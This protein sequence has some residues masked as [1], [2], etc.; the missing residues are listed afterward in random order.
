MEA[1]K[2]QID[3]TEKFHAISNA[4]NQEKNDSPVLLGMDAVVW[5]MKYY[6]EHLQGQRSQTT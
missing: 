2:T 3:K 1:I 4:L 5:V 6:Q